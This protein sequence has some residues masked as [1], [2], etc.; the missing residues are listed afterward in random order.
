MKRIFVSAAAVCLLAGCLAAQSGGEGVW[1]GTLETGGPKL[2]VVM[3]IIKDASGGYS[4]KLDS[5]DQGAFGIPVTKTTVTADGVKLEL[6]D[7]SAG[8]EGTLSMDGKTLV[9]NWSQGGGTLPLTMTRTTEEAVKQK[10]AVKGRLLFD[11]ERQFAIEHMERTRKL[12]LEATAQVSAEQAKFKPGPER[13]SILEIT[14]HIAAT[15]DFLFG[16]ATG[17]VMK[18]PSNF[19]LSERTVEQLMSAD[20]TLLKQMVD[21]GAKAQ[22]PEA[23][24]PAGRYATLAE[25][26]KAFEEKR[27]KTIAYLRETQDDLR[28]HGSPAPGGGVNDAYQ[29]LL[30]LA[31]HAERHTLQINE[32]KAAAGYPGK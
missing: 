23:A 4:T 9:G 3:H 20:Q 24:K 30:M 31:G 21:R 7:L 8:F 22:A 29:Y 10:P 13:W 11:Q 28:N 2:K 14:E 18:I 6:T 27:A 15:E 17:Q 5:P 16:F 26:R 12:V 25:A 32:V 19:G 1:V